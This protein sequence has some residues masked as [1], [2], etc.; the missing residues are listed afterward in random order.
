MLNVSPQFKEAIKKPS[1][2]MVAEVELTLTNG[3]KLLFTDEDLVDFSLLEELSSNEEVPF[4]G[5]SANEFTF[6]IYNENKKFSPSNTVS[7]YYGHMGPGATVTARVGLEISPDE[8]EYVPLGTFTV[9]DWRAPSSGVS[10]TI[11]AY[12]RLFNLSEEPIPMMR[13]TENTTVENMFITLFRAMGL[14]IFEFDVSKELSHRIPYGFIMPTT[15]GEAI[16]VLSQAGMCTVVVNRYNRI[17]VTP[18]I[19]STL[20]VQ[21]WDDDNEI[22]EIENPEKFSSVYGQMSVA[23]H[24]PSLRRTN[25]LSNMSNLTLDKG[26]SRLEKAEFSESPVVSVDRISLQNSRGTLIRQADYGTHQVSLLL[27]NPTE[28]T[29]K[30]SLSIAGVYCKFTKRELYNKVEDAINKKILTI[31]NPLVQTATHAQRIMSVIVPAMSDPFN[32][33]DLVVRGNPAIVVGDVIT[34]AAPSELIPETTIRIYRSIINYNGSIEGTI[35]GRR[36]V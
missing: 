18:S 31:D 26:E 35:V 15:F 9:D 24:E 32:F 29:E 27:E 12:D 19:T 33:F 4:G 16:K 5:V 11:V 25:S 8:F 14:T 6:S 7:P 30:V 2:Y 10:V 13:I 21:N 20:P 3:E 28:R 23:I 1:R 36:V 34:V 17:I 22:L